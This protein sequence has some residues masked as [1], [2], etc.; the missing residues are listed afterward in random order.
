MGHS[1]RAVEKSVSDFKSGKYE[2]HYERTVGSVIWDVI[3]AP[4]VYAFDGELSSCTDF[5]PA[6]K[7][8]YDV[9]QESLKAD[10]D[11]ISSLIGKYK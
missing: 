8:T 11:D 9:V 10:D 4:I 7:H 6:E 2:P 1:E 5:S 3:T